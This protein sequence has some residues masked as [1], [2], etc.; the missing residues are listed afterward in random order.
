MEIQYW[1]SRMPRQRRCVSGQS[2][3]HRYGYRL[4]LDSADFSQQKYQ[5]SQQFL[6]LHTDCEEEQ[7]FS[8]LQGVCYGKPILAQQNASLEEVYCKQCNPEEQFNSFH[9]R[10]ERLVLLANANSDLWCCFFATFTLA[11]LCHKRLDDMGRDGDHIGYIRSNNRLEIKFCSETTPLPST[12]IGDPYTEAL[13]Q[14]IILTLSSRTIL[15]R[16][17]QLFRDTFFYAP[18]G[19]PFGKAIGGHHCPEGSHAQ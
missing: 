11:G 9:F 16:P 1:H 15:E 12:C 3:F 6:G 8:H 2:A 5:I 4:I 13:S 19:H 17:K 7:N 14:H 18:V 10:I